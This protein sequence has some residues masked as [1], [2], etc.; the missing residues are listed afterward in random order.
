MSPAIY[1][2][3]AGMA[4]PVGLS[5]SSA[6]AA[7][8]AGVTS[9]SMSHYRDNTGREIIASFLAEQIAADASCEDRWLSLLGWALQDL[10][11]Q[12]AIPSLAGTPILLALASAS[13]GRP[14][15]AAFVADRLSVRLGQHIDAESV[16]IVSGGANA[17][18]LALERARGTLQT[19]KACIVAGADSLLAAR[20]LLVL[21]G[22]DRLLVEGNSDGIIPGEAAVAV[23]LSQDKRAA[24]A[25]VLGVGFG[26]EP[27]LLD[28]D[29][30][31]RADGLSA[32]A[33]G[34]LAQ[35]KL[36]LHEIDFCLSDAAGES[37]FFKEQALLLARLMRERKVEFP[38]WLGAASLGHT[39]AAAGLCNLAW[40]IA[41]WAR[42]Y[43]PGPRAIAFAG[44]ER[45][46][47][48]AVV[49]ERCG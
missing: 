18:Y 43:A 23:L 10:L 9:K 5:W 47:R 30:P 33:R 3:A 13:D 36:G 8:R 38:L 39:G 26:E 17:G 16:L 25:S 44:D 24:L 48:A 20:R 27:S 34:A 29:I 41:G 37:F 19:N 22:Q 1:V 2:R 7:M 12:G 40:A 6:C 11:R 49:I 14:Y 35:A 42:D 31:L 28:N 15:P 32:A 4:C 46:A 21:S 45:S